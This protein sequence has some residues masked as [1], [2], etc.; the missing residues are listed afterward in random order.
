MSTSHSSRSSYRAGLGL[1]LLATLLLVLGSGAVGVIGDGRADR[2]YLAVPA[3]LLLGAAATRL[4]APG[5][6][7]VALLA[8]LAVAVVPL[9]VL[10]SGAAGTDGVS[11]VDVTGLTLGFAGMY[12]VAAALFRRSVHRGRGVRA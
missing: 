2:G 5:M 12:V 1:T 6:A 10:G 4:R 11:L 7:V 8:A 9:V 3:V